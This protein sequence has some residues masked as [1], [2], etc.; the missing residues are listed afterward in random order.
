MALEDFYSSHNRTTR[1]RLHVR[2]SKD[3]VVQAA[4][5]A[6]DL[7]K[8]VQ[9]QAI[10]G[11][12]KSTQADFVI[13]IGKKSRVPIISSATSPS[14][15]PIENPYFI[16]AAQSGSSQVE[17]I[18]ALFKIFNWREVVLIYEEG[19]YRRGIVPYLTDQ[20]AQNGTQVRYR[21][22]ISVSASDDFILKEMHKLMRLENRVFVVH[23]SPSLASRFFL[24]A[25]EAGMTRKGYAWIITD[26]LTSF[27]DYLEPSVKDSMQGVIGVK[28]HVPNSPQLDN[29]TSRW[30][31]RFR[32]ENPE[33]ARFEL[34][35][36][37][38]WAYDTVTALALAMERAGVSQSEFKKT[39]PARNSTDLAGIGVSEN[40]PKLLQSIRNISLNRGLS[41]EFHLVNGQ[42]QSSAIEIVNVMERGGRRIGFWI[43][44]YGIS[45]NLEPVNKI[46]STNSKNFGPIMW[47]G[48]S[49]SAPK[50]W[51]IPTCTEK[52]MRIGIP[53]KAG[54]L[55]EFIKFKRD[56]Q[57]NGVNAS[58]LCVDLFREVMGSWPYPVQY[59]FI[60]FETSDG[61]SAGSYDDLVYQIFLGKYDAVVGD[62][63]ITANRSRYVEFT[64]PFMES[65]VAMVVPIKKDERKNWL[66][67][68][69]PLTKDMWLTT[70][71]FFVFIGFV[72]W[73]LEH[74]VN[75]EFRGP[76][77][78]QVGTVF[79]FSFSG[80]VFAQR[81]RVNNNLARFV[82]TVWMLVVLVLQSSYTASLSTMLT[83]D[84]LGPTVR[85][86][87]DLLNNGGNVGYQQGSFVDGFLKNMRFNSSKFRKYSSFKEYEEALS[88]GSKNGGV[89][90]IVDELPYLKLFLKKYRNKYTMVGPI[91]RTTGLGFAFPKGSPLAP[92]VS[93]AILKLVEEGKVADIQRKRLGEEISNHMEEEED[94]FKDSSDSL[95]L[96]SFKGLF[97]IAGASSCLALIIFLSIFLCENR[98]ILV[99]NASLRQK[100]V[101]MAKS[102]DEER[103]K[104]LVKKKT[105]EG[106]PGF[107]FFRSGHIHC[108]FPSPATGISHH[109]EGMFSRDEGFSAPEP[110][111]P[112]HDATKIVQTTPE[113]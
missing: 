60:P 76:P 65:G 42:L 50:G 97:V 26:V 105:D 84:K 10:L 14:L 112:V 67:F 85:D 106:R 94:G 75:R 27:F 91:Y 83:A 111:T 63:T 38:L 89:A 77:L 100:L 66:I 24:K 93:K 81:E 37:G 1:I 11:H 8:N 86:I 90:A 31:A 34:N 47:P 33:I 15:S 96:D 23:M 30:R 4:S 40:G 19:E 57:T 108:H 3:D 35:V 92:E 69:K 107:F 51:E 9:V 18:T 109:T 28:P 20:L 17:A 56:S 22:V 16:G 58:G 95:T 102:F 73:V 39:E 59:E 74:R 46:K 52:K 44:Q 49:V 25:K 36:F 72:V 104:K 54:D 5:S 45:K 43:P 113:R 29:F 71:A 53:A 41:G 79:W 64:V 110:G 48:A 13:D 99:S 7:L 103:E 70:A 87:K 101:A 55:G 61:Q 68:M 98:E 32:Q 82:L 2:D 6:I 88:K 12:S 80:L 78:Q 62:V 21:S